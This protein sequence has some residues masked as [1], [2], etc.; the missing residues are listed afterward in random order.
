MRNLRPLTESAAAVWS[1][2]LVRDDSKAARR[3]E[4]G[5]F[6]AQG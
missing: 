4:D 1:H 5:S 3:E 2:F 6:A